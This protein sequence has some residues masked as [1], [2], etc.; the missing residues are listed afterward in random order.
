MTTCTGDDTRWRV[1]EV[2]GVLVQILILGHNMTIKVTY[3]RVVQ[4]TDTIDIGGCI[5]QLSD[6]C[7]GGDC[8]SRSGKGNDECGE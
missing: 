1:E 5:A 3:V 6:K 8:A 4:S 7:S 2:E